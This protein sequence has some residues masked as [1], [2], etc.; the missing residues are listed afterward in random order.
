MWLIIIAVIFTILIAGIAYMVFAVGKFGL[1]Q[2]AGGGKRWKRVLVSL[3][4]IAAVFAVCSLAMSVVN[5][6]VV[7]IAAFMFFL[8][9]GIIGFA[10]RKISGRSG[11]NT[12]DNGDA[13]K[14]GINWPGWLALLA[15]V[16]YLAAG[17]YLC[18]NVWQTDY[19]LKTDKDLGKLKI[20]MFA[21]SHIGTT[22]DGKGFASELKKIEKQSP[23]ILLIPGDYVD[24]WSKK[25]DVEEACKALGRAKIKYGVWFAYGNHDEGR[26][27][28]RD[29]S[30]EE[31][32]AMLRENGV[33]IMDDACQLVDGRFYVAGRLDSM[34][35]DRKSMDELLKDVD[36]GK[37]IIVLDHEPNAYDEE[38][39]SAADLVVS[40]HTHGG[41]LFPFNEVGVIAGVNDRTYG[42]E[43]RKGTDFIVTSGISDW[44]LLFKTGTKS[45]YVMIDVEQNKYK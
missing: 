39:D 9:F 44:A 37:Y 10:L 6:I 5:A 36:T 8:L 18:N 2:K 40:G 35:S 20:A 14:K 41:Q 12:Y 43:K 33:H 7:M 1:I 22:F 45:E 21:D 19:D 16:I 24:D 13:K 31:L 30:A 27:R 28:E 32:E 3:A 26:F 4:L 23:D 17:Y 42:Y 38:A 25:E 34:L 29:F 11:A 15:T